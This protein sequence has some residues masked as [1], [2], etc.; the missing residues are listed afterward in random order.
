VLRPA[1]LQCYFREL[2]ILVRILA[3]LF[4]VF[5]VQILCLRLVA[6]CLGVFALLRENLFLFPIRIQ[7]LHLS[8]V[9]TLRVAAGKVASISAELN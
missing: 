9:L 1:A 8:A 3:P 6:L 7:K 2:R 4:S 5:A